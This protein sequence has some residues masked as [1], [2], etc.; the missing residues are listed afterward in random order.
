MLDPTPAHVKPAHPD[1]L[2]HKIMQSAY[3]FLASMPGEDPPLVSL[4]QPMVYWKPC[5]S[6]T[7]LLSPAGQTVAEEVLVAA[8]ELDE[9][10]NEEATVLEGVL[11]TRGL[12]VLMLST[13]VVLEDAVAAGSGMIEGKVNIF[14]DDAMELDGT[15]TPKLDDEAPML[16]DEI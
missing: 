2:S 10:V 13:T 4:P 15:A 12:A 9:R 7:P 8:E 6:V 5:E 14:E 11:D 3:E 1:V 16:D